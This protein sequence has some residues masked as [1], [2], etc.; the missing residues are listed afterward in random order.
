MRR[1]HVKSH[2]DFLYCANR[3]MAEIS[4][5]NL[6]DEFDFG[7]SQSNLDWSARSGKGILEGNGTSRDPWAA[8]SWIMTRIVLR[9]KRAD[10]RFSHSFW[11]SCD[12]W[13]LNWQ[14]FA[15]SP[16]VIYDV[17]LSCAFKCYTHTQERTVLIRVW[18]RWLAFFEL[19]NRNTTKCYV[20]YKLVWWLANS[21]NA[22]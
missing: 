12:Q 21:N 3:K 6:A 19:T 4:L 13:A 5:A 22:N 7:S 10:F 14:G 15:F 18:N 11:T 17:F 8:R 20:K 1:H 16:V 2:L 9:K